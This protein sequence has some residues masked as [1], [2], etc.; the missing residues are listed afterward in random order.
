MAYKETIEVKN[1]FYF[2]NIN[3]IGG[4]ETFFYNLARKYK[5]NDI[6][7]VYN[8]GD[9]AQIRRLKKYVRVEQFKGQDII[10]DKAFFNYSTSI[11]DC[12]KA[13]EYIQLIHADYEAQGLKINL[14]PKVTRYLCVSEHA[15]QAFERAA[16]VKAE[17]VY[18]PLASIQPKRVLHLI[19]ATRLT[20]EKGKQRILKLCEAFDKNNIPFTF[21]LIH[22]LLCN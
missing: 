8:T 6:L 10:C 20:P 18:N 14:N 21:S 3:S 19:S 11:I 5:N 1:M 2:A 13:E 22:H 12:V 15:R 7:I 17:L 16:G 4:V 9:Q